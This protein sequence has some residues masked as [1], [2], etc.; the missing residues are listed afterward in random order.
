MRRGQNQG[1]QEVRRVRSPRRG[2]IPGVVE[3]ILGHGKLKV[4][5]ADGKTRLTRIPGKMKKENMDQG[6]RCSSY[7]TMG[8]P[9]RRK[10]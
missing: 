2:E 5:C 9:E 3:Q 4:R 7:K 6:R 8:F 1:T 10:S